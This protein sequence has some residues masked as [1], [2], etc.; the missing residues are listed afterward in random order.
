MCVKIHLKYLSIP[1]KSSPYSLGQFLKM[2]GYFCKIEISLWFVVI[3]DEPAGHSGPTVNGD[4][5]RPP[6]QRWGGCLSCVGSKSKYSSNLIFVTLKMV[7]DG[8]KYSPNISLIDSHW[9]CD[10][11]T[12][13]IRPIFHHLMGTSAMGTQSHSI[14]RIFMQCALQNSHPA[15]TRQQFLIS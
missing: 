10:H 3:P 4:Q 9:K 12:R 13:N 15:W 7:W 2:K 6:H 14:A 8:Q 5:N 11:V 1:S